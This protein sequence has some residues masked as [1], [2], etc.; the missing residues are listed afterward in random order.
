MLISLLEMQ[1]VDSIGSRTRRGWRRKNR[2]KMIL[3][4]LVMMVLRMLLKKSFRLKATN[5]RRTRPT[6]RICQFSTT[7]IR[8]QGTLRLQSEL[9]LLDNNL[10]TSNMSYLLLTLLMP[11]SYPKRFSQS[12]TNHPRL[13]RL[14][15]ASCP[16]SN[17]RTN[18]VRSLVPRS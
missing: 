13:P 11:L 16:T 14:S 3:D 9:L 18:L 7:E 1:C 5:G 10:E 17:S 8:Q 15:P 12:C 2:V 4:L 6:K